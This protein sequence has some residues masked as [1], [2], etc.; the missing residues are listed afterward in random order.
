VVNIIAGGAHEG[1][2]KGQDATDYLASLPET[3]SLNFAYSPPNR[4]LFRFIHFCMRADIP[5]GLSQ[6]KLPQLSGAVAY[7][8]VCLEVRVTGNKPTQVPRDQKRRIAYGR[9]ER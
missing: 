4:S 7:L 6:H 8:P 1:V 2:E 5:S 3:L 9:T